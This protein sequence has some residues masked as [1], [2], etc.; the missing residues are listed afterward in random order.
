MAT[1]I[2][3]FLGVKNEV[4]IIEQSIAHLRSIGVDHIMVCDMSST[5]GTAEILQKYRSDNFS[6]LT[7]SEEAWDTPVVEQSWDFLNLRR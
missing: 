5:D 7:L 6:V 3:A 4:E 1:R 2:A